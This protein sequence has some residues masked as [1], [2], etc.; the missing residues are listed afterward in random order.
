MSDHECMTSGYPGTAVEVTMRGRLPFRAKEY[1]ITKLTHLVKLAPLAIGAIRVKISRTSYRFTDDYVV[2][3]VSLDADGR[4]VRVQVVAGN[5]RTGIDLA[6]ERLRRKLNQLGRRTARLPAA[7]AVDEAIFDMYLLDYDFQLFID[8]LSGVD[9]VVYRDG[10]TGYRIT[11]LDGNAAPT[12]ASSPVLIDPWKAP[13][14]TLQEASDALDAADSAFLFYADSRS[15]RGNV[16]YR[17][18]DGHYGLIG[19]PAGQQR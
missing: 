10:G 14:L 11:R 12:N 3:E 5:A 13:G 8:A 17:R 15:G 1:A 4:P 6:Q 2:V 9:S 7:S 16:L 19:L 18:H